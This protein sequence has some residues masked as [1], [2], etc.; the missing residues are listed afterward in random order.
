MKKIEKVDDFSGSGQ[1][2]HAAGM[3]TGFGMALLSVP[4]SPMNIALGAVSLGVGALSLAA[5]KW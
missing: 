3:I 4:V 5:C 1:C 2:H